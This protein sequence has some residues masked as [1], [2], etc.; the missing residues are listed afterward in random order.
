MRFVPCRSPYGRHAKLLSGCDLVADS[1]P[2]A[3]FEPVC[4]PNNGALS[5]VCVLDAGV[6][7]SVRGRRVSVREGRA[8]RAHPRGERPGGSGAPDLTVSIVMAG[9]D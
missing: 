5:S 2:S 4:G 7:V 9:S 6:G 3:S 1:H 8:V